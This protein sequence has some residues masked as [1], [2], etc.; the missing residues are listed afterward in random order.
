LEIGDYPG[1]PSRKWKPKKIGVKRGGRG[2]F[3]IL[4]DFEIAIR[5]TTKHFPNMYGVLFY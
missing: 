1:F 3:Y 5:E 2:T 4:S